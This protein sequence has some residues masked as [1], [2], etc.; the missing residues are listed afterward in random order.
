MPRVAAQ[1]RR[2]E[3]VDAT[4]RV[5]LREGL[6]AATVRR[7]AQEA[8]VSLGTVHYCFGSKQALLQAVVESIEAP[9]VD[10]ATDPD[11]GLP[12]LIDSAFR[13][14]WAQAGAN[15]ERQQLIY[16]LVNHLSRQGVDGRALATQ[17]LE[18]NYRLVEQ[19]VEANA[20]RLAPLGI[21]PRMVARMIIAITDGVAVAWIADGDGDAAQEVLRNFAGVMGAAFTPRVEPGR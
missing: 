14:Y 21:E 15:R 16:E 10:I 8:G 4:V 3:L 7:I 9:A 18:R 2:Q 12:E 17:I 1:V 20:D 19:V 13:S 5:A 11:G 6:E